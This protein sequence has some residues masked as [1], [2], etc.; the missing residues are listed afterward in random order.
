MTASSRP[1]A[2]E[3][4]RSLKDF[5]RDSVEY[6]F[7]QLFRSGG[8]NR[9]LLADE[10]GLGKTMV[11]R[12]VIARV[13]EHLWDRK[14][15]IDIAYICSNAEIARQNINRLNI[16][17]H[18]DFQIASRLTLL[19][20]Q[21]RRLENNRINFIALTPGTSF[22]LRSSLGTAEERWLLYWL[23]RSAWPSLTTGKAAMNVLE[24]NQMRRKFRDSIRDYDPEESI[25]AGLQRAFCK[26]LEAHDRLAREKGGIPCRQVFGDLC[27]QFHGRAQHGVAPAVRRERDRLVGE[28][29][30]L[31]AAT[32]IEALRPD[33][34]VM[35]EFQ[36]FKDLLS[37]DSD[38][39]GLARCLFEGE[40]AR[41]LLLS[42]TPYKMYTVSGEQEDD[43]Y[44]DFLDTLGF[45]FD[46]VGRKRELEALLR[47]Y[48]KQL[49]RLDGDSEG[50]GLRRTKDAIEKQLRR[51]M[52]RTERLSA[53]EDRD[54]MLREVTHGQTVPAK[55]DVLAYIQLQRIARLMG[56]G[57]VIEY[58]KAAPYLLN[59]MENYELKR[60]FRQRVESP[61][62]DPAL[63]DCL[64]GKQDSFLPLSRIDAYEPLEPDNPRV[65]RLTGELLDSGSWRMLWIA[66]SLPYYRPGAP[67]DAPEAWTMTKRL[68]FSSWA[69]V[70]RALSFLLSYE[71]ERLMMM[72]L[73]EDGV[74]YAAYASRKPLL[75][76]TRSHDRLTGMPVLGL[77]YPS[78]VLARLADPLE[79]GLKQADGELPDIRSL[80][81]AARRRLDSRL[82]GIIAS[83]AQR[84][85]GRE[86]EA[87]YWAAPILLDLQEHPEISREW[88]ANPRLAA[89]WS[90]KA[91]E[92]GW[93]EHVEEARQL[94]AGEIVLG[95]PPENLPE[96]LAKLAVAGP[97]TCALRALKRVVPCGT[98]DEQDAFRL[99]A[100]KVAWGFRSLFNL[101]TSMNLIRG[102]G[103]GEPYWES[104][105]DYG[106]AGC[107]QSVLDEYAHVLRESL[108]LIDADARSAAGQ[109]AD[110][111]KKVVGI[112]AATP[113]VDE[114]R[115]ENESVHINP[116]RLR[117]RY[118][119][120]FGD[121]KSDG[122]ADR[123]RGDE[124]RHAFN[125]PFRPFVL[126]TTSVGQEGLD[127]HS[128][129]HAV[130]HWNLPRNPV[131]MEQREGR[132]H[133]YKGHAVRRNVARRYGPLL[134][135]NGAADPWRDVFGLAA[136]EPGRS[137]DLTPFWIYPNG[138]AFIE[139]HVPMLPMSR[140][141]GHLANL[142]RSLAVYRMVFGQP[143][144][145]DLLDHLL[146][147][148]PPARVRQLLDQLRIDLSPPVPRGVR[149]P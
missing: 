107:L 75:N 61:H 53:S 104:V 140:E 145:E 51:V 15:R 18:A 57:S 13:V 125:S 64:T 85:G 118:A 137:S 84:S 49:Y 143:R 95:R 117:A 135:A 8:T 68:V 119:M 108:G 97:A 116:R 147:R 91:G 59:F 129:C 9:F 32:C 93:D 52:S 141:I 20:M 142:R 62:A 100:G 132:I 94:V 149:S 17:R 80:L 120:R 76:F 73:S 86:D 43:H 39:G 24:G 148:L 111:M 42:A 112:H 66:P 123:F 28:L 128:Y 105:L 92:R 41:V 72:S 40:N 113:Q 29:R 114:I 65:R 36:R 10:V 138:T 121:E 48:R 47:G 127:F 82:R 110:V 44:A 71:A 21:V 139:R 2:D 88:W 122:S 106:T 23:L 83:H 38:A 67:F 102:L 60:A 103:S 63:V 98:D 56:R 31:L 130:V 144:Q 78:R 33:L 133:R 22:N 35:D 54:G 89:D 37:G 27:E 1:D 115:V 74:D 96:I 34:I 136:A 55:E 99:A 58:W 3:V 12:G 81:A 77:L 134:P 146:R 26:K 101:P 11:A 50:E 69:V 126:V 5:Q 30:G 16:T 25:D 4:L 14:E 19:P 124:V 79:I 46:D 70:P 7:E 87:W 6:I 131:D 90:G 109:I 45:L